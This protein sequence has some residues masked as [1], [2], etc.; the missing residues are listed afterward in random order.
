M[1]V[2]AVCRVCGVPAV[3]LSIYN[4]SFIICFIL[5]IIAVGLGG[6]STVFMI[7]GFAIIFVAISTIALLFVPKFRFLGGHYAS[8]NTTLKKLGVGT[9]NTQIKSGDGSD[10]EGTTP[11]SPNKGS[12]RKDNNYL[13]V[14][15]QQHNQNNTFMQS[16]MGNAPD[17]HGV[18]MAP[19]PIIS[20]VNVID[21]AQQQPGAAAL[22]AVQA[23]LPGTIDEGAETNGNGGGG[24]D[25]KLHV[26]PAMV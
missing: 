20:P 12:N 8:G 4:T 18:S 17:E 14:T 19:L 23:Q 2:R 16:E 6:R 5:P 25:V 1:S 9:A 15:N 26:D 22:Y 3:A 13:G 7:R 10:P 21:S 24:G 11:A